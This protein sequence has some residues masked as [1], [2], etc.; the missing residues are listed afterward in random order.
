MSQFIPKFPVKVAKILSSHGMCPYQL[1]FL[2]SEGN[3][4]YLRYRGGHLRCGI[5]QSE[6]DFWRGEYKWTY[7][8]IDEKI[9]D[10]YDGAPNDAEFKKY[11]EGKL[12]LSEGFN[13]ED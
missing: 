4:G 6:D 3:W 11:L 5:A 9:G 1:E 2:D 13:F 10:D 7:N 8:V 12:I